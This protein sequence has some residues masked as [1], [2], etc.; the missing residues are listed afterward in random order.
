MDE[1][2]RRFIIT[3]SGVLLL[4]CILLVVLSVWPFPEPD[5]PKNRPDRVI[6]PQKQSEIPDTTQP[7]D[8]LGGKPIDSDID[9]EQRISALEKREAR[10]RFVGADVLAE[11]TTP[12][13]NGKESRV[14]LLQIDDFAFPILVEEKIRTDA[15]GRVWLNSQKAMVANRLLIMPSNEDTAGELK[16]FA[17]KE[18]YTLEANGPHSS[19]LKMSSP[20]VSLDAISTM[21]KKL[22][23]LEERGLLV[24]E[25]ERLPVFS[26]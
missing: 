15:D 20:E 11:K 8:G 17:E 9:N 1:S 26:R 22:A 6:Q 19:V 24:A 16:A 7:G 21:M 25:P 3:Y 5:L 23:P 4:L 14:R 12:L 2:L 13:E 18:G 10:D